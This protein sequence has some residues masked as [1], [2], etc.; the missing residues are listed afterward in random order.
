MPILAQLIVSL[1]TTLVAFFGRFMVAE[2]AYRA[3][4]VVIMIG[5]AG[6]VISVMSSCA[7]G[8]CAQGISSI[9]SSHPNFAV[10]LGV[11]FNSITVAAA[12][13]Y[14]AVWTICQIYV[15]QKKALNMVVN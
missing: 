15:L 13:G 10:G 8:V 14:M 6:G 7:T 4:G 1:V 12:G 3:A 2:K 11:A 9:A 5:L